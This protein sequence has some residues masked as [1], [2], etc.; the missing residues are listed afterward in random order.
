MKNEK[1]RKTETLFMKGN[2]DS[3]LVKPVA[4]VYRMLSE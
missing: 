3:L 1:K 2:I 4:I